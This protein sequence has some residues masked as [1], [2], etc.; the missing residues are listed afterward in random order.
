MPNRPDSPPWGGAGWDPPTPLPRVTKLKRIS[1]CEP[2][3]L[4]QGVCRLRQGVWGVA[5]RG[6]G[7]GG[8]PGGAVGWLGGGEVSAAL[9]I[10]GVHFLEFLVSRSW[11][12]W[13][14]LPWGFYADNPTSVPHRPQ[15]FGF[16]SVKSLIAECIW[17]RNNSDGHAVW[18]PPGAF[19]LPGPCPGAV[20]AGSGP[21]PTPASRPRSGRTR[22]TG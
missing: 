5:L 3:A 8:A 14:L 2:R 19:H 6:P 22:S 4:L 13:C 12:S 10:L 11:D 16:L 17:P 9:G 15:R 1:D 20:S 21:P 18:N 7:L